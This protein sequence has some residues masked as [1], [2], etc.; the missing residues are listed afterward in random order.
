MDLFTVL[1]Q[2]DELGLSLGCGKSD[3]VAAN[4]NREERTKLIMQYIAKSHRCCTFLRP[5]MY[6][7]HIAITVQES[8][9]S[10][11][12]PMGKRGGIS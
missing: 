6:F 5:C 11:T 3:S 7:E 2:G 1:E 4:R 10:V 8:S 9:A 12:E